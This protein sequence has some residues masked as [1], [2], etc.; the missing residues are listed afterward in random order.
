MK[1]YTRIEA[2][3]IFGV[4]NTSI[5]NYLKNL[6]Q[7]GFSD[8]T[9]FTQDGKLTE[10]A[11][12]LIGYLRDKNQ[13]RLDEQL[14]LEPQNIPTAHEVELL[15]S[16]AITPTDRALAISQ[17]VQT[18]APMSHQVYADRAA[19]SREALN[20][21]LAANNARTA[22]LANNAAVKRRSIEEIATET[23]IGDLMHYQSRYADVLAQGL[24]HLQQS[25]VALVDSL[26][27]DA[28]NG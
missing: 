21:F 2:G 5:K 7:R 25:S 13:D 15:P 22:V 4:S 23:A 20:A 26:G 19:T 10:K 27:K 12:E 17:N 1:T 14:G 24:A 6:V 8:E 3:K 18:L 11:I 16:D 9:L 28:K